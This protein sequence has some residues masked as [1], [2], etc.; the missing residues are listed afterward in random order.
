MADVSMT[1]CDLADCGEQALI[2][3]N[4]LIGDLSGVVVD[5]CSGQHFHERYMEILEVLHETGFLPQGVQKHGAEGPGWKQPNWGIGILP[6]YQDSVKSPPEWSNHSYESGIEASGHFGHVH[7][8]GDPL[9]SEIQAQ[10]AIKQANLDAVNEEL[11]Q[12]TK[13]TQGLV[14]DDALDDPEIK[15]LYSIQDSEGETVKTVEMVD[16]YSP[17][18]PKVSLFGK[19]GKKKPA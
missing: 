14:G 6:P 19:L 7:H 3:S 13:F 2:R 8:A 12:L 11:E 1:I 16:P 18:K 10:L 15:T 4:V 5:A 17:T 9:P